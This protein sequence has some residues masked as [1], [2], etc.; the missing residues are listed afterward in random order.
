MSMY[1]RYSGEFLSISDVVWRVEI[2][3]ESSSSFSVK[4]LTFPKDTPLSIEWPEVD[5]MEPVQSSNA[6]LMVVSKTDREFVDLYTT[7]Q[8]SIRMDVY[9][10]NAIY[11]SGTL[12]TEIYEEPFACQNE[13]E[14][15]L[16]FSDFAGLDR[17]KFEKNSNKLWSLRSLYNLCIQATGIHYSALSEYVSTTRAGGG[18]LLNGTYLIDDNFFDE[19][20]EPMTLREV[21]DETLRPFALRMIQKDGHVIIYDINAVYGTGTNNVY[22]CLDDSTLSVDSTYNNVE[23]TFSPYMKIDLIESEMEPE[24]VLYG[25]EYMIYTD[26]SGDNYPGFKITLSDS[27][28]NPE[29]MKVSISSK[30]FKIDPIWS[31]DSEAGI[32]MVVNTRNAP[33]DY[34]ARASGAI[35]PPGSVLCDVKRKPY[36][37]V[38]SEIQKKYLL[39]LKVE[40]LV[41]VKYNPFEDVSEDNEEGYCKRFDEFANYGYIPIIINLRDQNGNV[42]HHY[43]NKDAIANGQTLPSWQGGAS[44]KTGSASLGDAYIA[45]YNK[46]HDDRHD[47]T[48]FG[49]WQTNHPMTG[50]HPHALFGIFDKMF[51]GDYIPMPPTS[52]WIEIAIGDSLLILDGDG[53]EK[54]LDYGSINWFLLKKV[55]LSLVDQYGNE[56]DEEDVVMKAWITNTAKEDM[57]IDT[58][59]GTMPAAHPTA[60]GQFFDS[61]MNVIS[62]FTRAGV[63]DRAEKLLCGTVYSQ[64]AG[65]KTKLSGTCR[66]LDGFRVMRDEHES[67]QFLI[68]SEIQNVIEDES[69]IVMS[70]IAADNYTGIEYE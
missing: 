68:V 69:E 33:K 61:S 11:W 2:W 58:V 52:G 56:L 25:S 26:Y 21:L 46:A 30:Y 51:D 23:L 43:D 16:T 22:W 62:Q 24:S 39:N 36:V 1:K 34:T 64:Y 49:G 13:Y 5:R 28:N 29:F 63:T 8:G 10:N 40:V 3:Q 60:R 42:T 6:T 44:W 38:N 7:I 20:D 45:Y 65:R 53:Y 54:K 50:Y 55:N 59:A 9:R 18:S 14:V 4:N 17:L 41:D 15:T 67:G 37:F 12:D 19:D 47:K 32:A 70:Q 31:G 66:L 57:T 27:S 48:C 35:Q